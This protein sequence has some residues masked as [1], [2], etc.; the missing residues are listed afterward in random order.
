LGDAARLD[1]AEG[2]NDK[3]VDASLTIVDD[4]DPEAAPVKK[5]RSKMTMQELAAEQAIYPTEL[6]FTES[7]I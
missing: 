4:D 7:Q 1:N 3:A 5:D 6:L 2:I